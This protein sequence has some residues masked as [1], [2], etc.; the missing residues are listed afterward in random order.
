MNPSIDG[1]LR[2]IKVGLRSR[3]FICGVTVLA[4]YAYC[5]MGSPIIRLASI[6]VFFVSAEVMVW[7]WG[8]FFMRNAVES[9]KM[10]F[11]SKGAI[12]W[13]DIPEFTELAE[14]MGVRLHRARP[15]GVMKGLN[16]AFA[17]PITRQVV[18]GGQLL[19]RLQS[20]ERLALGAHEFTH[21]K[22]QHF[23]KMLPWLFVGPMLV[24]LSLSLT[25]SPAIIVNLACFAIFVV[26]FVF[27]SWR[28]EFA[29]DAGAASQAG[30]EA[31]ILL[32]QKLANPD[33]WERES[34][35]HPAI[36]ER[37]CRLGKM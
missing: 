4:A 17:N 28:N 34:E 2:P 15:F 14:R 36:R 10:R 21:I 32:L 3:L 27:A 5:Y 25:P 33:D 24:G 23:L 18:F 22:E 35:T 6:L 26:I 30:Q 12:S 19:Q 8:N 7:Q 31:A 11:F 13:R 16:N 37:I 29:A 9:F 20:Q 1:L